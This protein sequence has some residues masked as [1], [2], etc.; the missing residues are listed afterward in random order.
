MHTLTKY[1]RGYVGIPQNDEDDSRVADKQLKNLRRQSIS[2]WLRPLFILNV[3]FSVILITLLARPSLRHFFKHYP[4]YVSVP[5]VTSCGTTITEA[6]AAK[7]TFDYLAHLWLPPACSQKE[8]GENYTTFDFDKEP[9]KY[10]LS[11]DNITNLTPSVDISLQ[12]LGSIVYSK[13]KEHLVHCALTLLR[14]KEWMLKGG[15]WE[16]KVLSPEH[17]EHCVTLLLDAT[18]YHPQFE[19]IGASASLSFSGSCYR[20]IVD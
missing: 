3:A 20:R 2:R 7:C 18:K 19:E 8:Y 17:F 13:T 15:E 1:L 16:R 4:T 9:F 10:Y 14:T 11:P 12:P 5:T 6:K